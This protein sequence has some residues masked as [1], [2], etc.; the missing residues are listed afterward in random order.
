M[1]GYSRWLSLVA[2]GTLALSSARAD[3]V[4]FQSNRWHI[5]AEES[6][7]EP[8]MGQTSLYLKN[9]LAYVIDSEFDNGT[10]EFDIAFSRERG[11]TGGVWRLQDPANYEE[12]Y[13]RPHQSGNPDANQYTPVFNRSTGWQLY[14]GPAYGAPTEY[15]FDQ[16]MPV[17]I[18]V[19]DMQAEVYIRD[20]ETPAVFIP[21]MKRAREAGAV[22]VNAY[23]ASARFA[24]FRYEP[25]DSPTL[26]GHGDLPKA[27][28]E[29]AI[30]AWQVS[31]PF[32]ERRLENMFTL[33]DAIRQRTWTPLESERSGI[34]NLARLHGVAEGQNTVFA[35]TTLVTEHPRRTRLSIGYSDNVKVYL[36]GQLLY[37]GTNFYESR[38][39]RYLG[40]I[41]LFDAVC[42]DL[43]AGDN[44]LW[45]AVS[46]RFGGWG[47]MAQLHD[48]AVVYR[49][50]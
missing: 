29:G 37:D 6:R 43:G 13:L 9:G 19:S 27:A 3:T 24:N 5:D 16:W 47:I 44:Q 8:Y 42:L 39:Y 41:G 33:D 4:S 36:N 48:D 14:H 46:E 11:F 31:D 50:P 28:P 20:M 23:F 45:M 15:V 1:N 34:A 7:V 2:L 35:R 26:K 30:M 22:G 38:D 12:F 10:I 18:V 25:S 40:T 49:T 17:R 21:D 32:D